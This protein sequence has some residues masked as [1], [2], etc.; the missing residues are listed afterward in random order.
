ME[1]PIFNSHQ[2]NKETREIKTNVFS[3]QELLDLIY[4]GESLPQDSRFLPVGE[5]GVFKYFSVSD[6]SGPMSHKSEK[7]FLT[8]AEGGIVVGLAELEQNPYD[9]HN[10]WLK[11]VSV[12]PLYQ[13]KG[14]VN[15]LIEQIFIFTKQKNSTLGVSYYSE[16]GEEKIRRTIE[17]LSTQT[18]VMLRKF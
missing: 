8:I 15:T 5:G 16:E 12:D 10:L 3:T 14:Y 1:K 7:N 9:E 11:F 6:L 4:K 2:E 17:K 18:G 13:N